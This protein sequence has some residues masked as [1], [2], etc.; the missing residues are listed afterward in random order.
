M[1]DQDLLN[2]A[3][4]EAERGLAEGGL[5]IGSILANSSGQIIARGHNLR[6]QTGDPTAHAETVCIRNAGRRRD[7][8][9]LTLVST[10][11]PCIMCTGTSLLYKIPRVII[12]ENQ[13]FRGAEE[14]F[15]QHNVQL[16]N[17]NDPA[18]VKLMADFIEKHPDLWNEDIGIPS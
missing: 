5:P 14:L 3:I 7:W 4:K 17:L 12:G 9:T 8:H 6:V 11:S 1:T 16:I 10:L 15:A 18:C 13:N 2:E